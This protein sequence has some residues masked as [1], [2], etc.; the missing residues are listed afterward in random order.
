VDNQTIWIS[1]SRGFIGNHL[2][3]YLKKDYLVKSLSNGPN[4]KSENNHIELNFLKA[5]D[6]QKLISNNSVPD[7]FIHL[8]WGSMTDPSSKTHI[9]ENINM[10]KNL[11][12]MLY[13]NGLKKFLFLG[14]M[15]EYG[16]LEGILSENMKSGNVL[17]NYAKGKSIVG[18]YGIQQ[19]KLKNKIFIHMRLFYTFGPGQRSNSLINLI[20]RFFKNNEIPEFYPGEKYRDYIYI[21]DVVKGIKLLC[22]VNQS[23]IVNLGSGKSTKLQDFILKFWE[24]LGGNLDDLKFVEK[25]NIDE[26]RQP[27]CFSDQT[28]LYELIKWKPIITVDEGI[29]LTVDKLKSK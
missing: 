21:D 29:Q 10:S 25:I 5:T 20:Y 19:A 27:N 11:I 24:K 26:E 12:D 6:L 15:T 1:G 14:S 23:T 4:Y 7:I 2:V 13:D 22:N 9:H 28:R 3:N 8:G 17:T 16:G 18:S